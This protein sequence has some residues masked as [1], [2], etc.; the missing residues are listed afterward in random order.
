MLTLAAYILKTGIIQRLEWL[1]CMHNMQILKH[2][3]FFIWY[4]YVES[5]KRYKWIYLQNRNRVNDVENL[6]LSRGKD[7]SGDWDWHMYVTIYKMDNNKNLLY[8]TGNSTQ[9]SVLTYMGIEF[10][11]R[12]NVYLCNWSTLLCIR[13]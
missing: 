12:V 13:N 5:K 2:F 1:L 3:I 9:Y 6:W 10:F 4:T 7:K 8:S 11:K